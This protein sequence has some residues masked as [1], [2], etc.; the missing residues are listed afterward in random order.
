MGGARTEAKTTDLQRRGVYAGRGLQDGSQAVGGGALTSLNSWIWAC[1]NIEKTLEEPRWACLVA[2]ALPL[3]PAFLLACNTVGG[4]GSSP[5]LPK[6]P[7][8]HTPRAL[9]ER[10][11]QSPLPVP[12]DHLSG[13]NTGTEMAGSAPPA[14]GTVSGRP[15]A[16][17]PPTWHS[18]SSLCGSLV[19]TRGPQP[20]LC[21]S[22][23]TYNT[24]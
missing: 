8:V 23:I 4:E 15:L 20:P 3:V 19:A 21:L 14:Q 11:L 18:P 22:L 17:H 12:G 16:S 5:W 13:I 9:Q 6:D 1:S 24:K 10:L 2:P 7:T